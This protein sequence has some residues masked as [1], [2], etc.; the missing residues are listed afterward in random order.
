MKAREISPPE[1][2]QTNLGFLRR[3]HTTTVNRFLPRYPLTPQ[4]AFQIRF[5]IGANLLGVLVAIPAIIVSIVTGQPVSIALIGVFMLALLGQLAAVR[6]GF[7]RMPWMVWSEMGILGAFLTLQSLATAELEPTQLQWFLLIP[8]AA[9][10]LMDPRQRSSGAA[11]P[12][13][14]VLLASI[15]AIAI[16]MGVIAAK[17]FGLTF[18]GANSPEILLET[19]VNFLLFMLA[20][21]GL[22]YLYDKTLRE[23]ITELEALRQL[24]PLCA[25]CKEIRG[26]DGNWTPIDQYV[27]EHYC[28]ITHSICPGCSQKHFA[29]HQV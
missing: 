5:M 19:L 22:I 6:F 1:D 11:F 21:C 24:L 2:N 25:W 12:V 17:R 4:Q 13:G 20:M 9:L 8:L 18:G 16:G 23:A 3:A 7:L 15:I 28:E 29:K 10:V 27:A 26:N 14:P